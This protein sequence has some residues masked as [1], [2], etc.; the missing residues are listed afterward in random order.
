MRGEGG[1]RGKERVVVERR[2]VKER[3]S[4][5]T[6]GVRRGRRVARPNFVFGYPV[7]SPPNPSQ[8]STLFHSGLSA[9]SHSLCRQFPRIVPN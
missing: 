7:V 4:T 6:G 8:I 3:G 2:F 1:E 9:L 5:G